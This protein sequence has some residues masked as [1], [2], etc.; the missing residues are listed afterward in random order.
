MVDVRGWD[1]DVDVGD[2]DEF[3]ERDVVFVQ[4][5]G[6]QCAWDW[7]VFIELCIGDTSDDTR[8]PHGSVGIEWCSTGDGDVDGANF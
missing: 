4:G 1:V 2:G 5:R 8:C 3:G 6:D 7:F